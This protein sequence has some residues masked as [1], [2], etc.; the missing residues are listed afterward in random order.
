MVV[1]AV[2]FDEALVWAERF[3]NIAKIF[4]KQ[5]LI[6]GSRSIENYI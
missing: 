2:L 6:G 4:L 3:I 1:H 5:E